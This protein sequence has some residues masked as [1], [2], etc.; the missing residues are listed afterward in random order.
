MCA[1]SPDEH[2]HELAVV[3]HDAV[4][5]GLKL[6]PKVDRLP[7]GGHNH[8]FWRQQFLRDRLANQRST[9]SDA[10]R[11]HIHPTVSERVE[12]RGYDD[13]GQMCAET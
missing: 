8:L 4:Q 2:F 12:G 13:K 3:G 7:G 1:R 10:A 9:S 11:P 6:H 5:Q